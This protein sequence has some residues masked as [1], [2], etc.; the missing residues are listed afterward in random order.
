LDY[1][2]PDSKTEVVTG[3]DK[4]TCVEIH[5][6][7]MVGEVGFDLRIMKILES[8]GVSYIS[9]ATNANTIGIVMNDSDCIDELCGELQEKFEL[10]TKDPVAI[11]CAIGSNIARPGVL[12]EAAKALAEANINILAVSQTARQTN[13]QFVVKREHFY[14][15]QRALHAALCE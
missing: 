11:V 9:K 5:D 10:V 2:R 6:T 12:S 7:R 3:S 4:V 13:M 14:D 1:I 8:H 15:A